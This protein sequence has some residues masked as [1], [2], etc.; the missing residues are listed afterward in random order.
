MTAA[1]ER[2]V[3]AHSYD[4]VIVGAGSRNLVPGEH[5]TRR[6][7]AAVENDRFRAPVGR[8]LPSAAGACNVRIQPAGQAELSWELAP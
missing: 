2:H 4:L 1:R 3:A 8:S 5:F 7:I 6:Q